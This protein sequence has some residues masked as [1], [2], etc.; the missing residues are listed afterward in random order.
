LLYTTK[1]IGLIWVCITLKMPSTT[2]SVNMR[3]F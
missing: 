3:K 2:K 1:K